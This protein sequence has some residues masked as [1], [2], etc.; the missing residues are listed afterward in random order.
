MSRFERSQATY[1]KQTHTITNWPAYDQALV[2]RGSLTFWF[3]R[4]S[5]QS[6]DRPTKRAS[7]WTAQVLEPGHRDGAGV[8][9]GVS[10][11]VETDQG[12]PAVAA[13]RYTRVTLEIPHDTTFSHRANVSRQGR[14]PHA[15]SGAPDAHP[16][17]QYR[18]SGFIARTWAR[19]PRTARGSKLH[20][21]VV[22][23]TA[24]VAACDLGSSHA[25]DAA[26]VPALLTQVERPL[27]WVA[28]DS[29]YDTERAVYS[30]R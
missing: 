11:P 20:L 17:G 8:S 3:D 1:V 22:T 25:R 16:R 18:A 26:R 14:V 27:A 29:A 12:L 24:D 13:W 19:R 23:K 28:A 21:V 7:W 30:R 4:R 15:P 9:H 5:H 2:T 10:S 6:V